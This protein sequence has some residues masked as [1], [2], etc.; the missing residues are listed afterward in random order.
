MED[1]TRKRVKWSGSNS[2]KY[3]S[4]M[5]LE[6]EELSIEG[7]RIEAPQAPWG[8]RVCRTGVGR[9]EM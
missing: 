5:P 1:Y 3:V 7:E 4:W 9:G 8:Y 2:A 6:T